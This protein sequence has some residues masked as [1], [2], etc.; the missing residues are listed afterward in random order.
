[1]SQ[2]MGFHYTPCNNGRGGGWIVALVVAVGICADSPSQR[3]TRR[4]R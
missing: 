3:P 2:R 1:M 4:T